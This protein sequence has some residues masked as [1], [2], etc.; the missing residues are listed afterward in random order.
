MALDPVDAVIVGAGGGG[1]VVA[2]EL[3]RQGWNV[4]LL[5]RG[6]VQEF[7]E[8]GHHE[9]RSQRTTVLGNA[10][11]P[12]D[13]EHPRIRQ[14]ERGEWVRVY[15]SEGGYNN[16]AAVV[17][18]GTL[19]YGAMAWRFLPKDFQMK[20]TYGAPANSTLEDWPISYEDLA[21]YYEKAEWEIGVSGKRGSNPFDGPRGKEYPM[22]PLPFNREATILSK[23]AKGLGLHPFPIPMAINSREYMGRPGCVQC[24]HCVGFRCEV[25]AKSS[26][27]VTVIPRAVATGNCRLYTQAVA[28]EI[29]LDSQGRARA[30]AYFNEAGELVEQPTRVVIVACG[31]TESARLLLNSKSK[32]HPNGLGNRHDWVGRNLQGHAYSGAFGLFDEEI[33]DGLGPGARLALCDYNHGNPG[34]TGGGMLANEFIRLPY[35]FA[36]GVRP[37]GSPRWGKAHKDFQR[38]FY[39][40]SMGFKSPVQEVP[41]WEARVSIDPNVRDAWGIPVLRLSGQRHEEDLKTGR[42]MAEKAAEVLKAAGA[43][44]VWLTPSGRGLS[45]GQHQAG[46]ARMSKDP[47]NGA[48]DPHCRLH[49]ADNVFLA[50]GSP[51]VT[52]GGFNPSLTIQALAFRTGEYIAKSGLKPRSA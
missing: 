6:R 50:D 28:K 46:T 35:L 48:A 10:F 21:P 19:S 36:R 26:T 43:K 13:R 1:G 47:K 34:I 45:G 30:V 38:K 29:L 18:G 32:L 31:A 15:P 44:Q 4:A 33:Y 39:R 22:P 11:G 9:L 40:H 16:I 25:D 52:N 42:F 51:H 8:T 27:A 41:N 24:P 20:S 7:S 17:G 5:E 3:A 14:N 37:P 49:D 23:A 12:S 2:Y